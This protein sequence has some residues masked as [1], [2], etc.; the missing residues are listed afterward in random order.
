MRRQTQKPRLDAWPGKRLRERKDRQRDR[1]LAERIMLRESRQRRRE[2][3]R[4]VCV[5]DRES[6]REK[7]KASQLLNEGAFI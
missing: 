1:E 5:R 6:K 4:D 3:E 2:R 7:S